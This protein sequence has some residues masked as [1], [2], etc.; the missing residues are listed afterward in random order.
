MAR[1]KQRI[2]GIKKGQASSN[3]DR[4]VKNASMRTR[5]TINRLNMYKSGG[6]AI[7]DRA[8]KIIKPAEFQ[9]QLKSGSVARVEPNRKWFGN[10]RV[11]GQEAL[12]KFQKELGNAVKDPFK[13]V[14]RTSK[15]P[16][17]LLDAK[18]MSGKE[19]VHILDTEPYSEVFSKNRRRKRPNLSFESLAQVAEKVEEKEENYKMEDDIDL[20]RENDGTM[21]HQRNPLLNAGQSKRIWGELY[22]VLDSS[23]VIIQVLDARDPQG[24]RSH[25]IEKYLEKEKPHK[26]LVFL[27][28]K[29]D[30]QPI[31]VTRK[32]VQL[33][34]KERP[35]LA[36]H[37]SITNPFGKGA[38]ISLL[39]QFALLHK[40]KKSIS[41]GFIGYP[42]VG[43]SSVINTM[44]KKKVCNVA[45]I[46]GETKVWQFVALTKRVFLIDCPGVVYSGQQHDETELILRGVCRVENID[47][48]ASHV[49]EV[50]RRAEHVHLAKLYQITGWEKDDSGIEFLEMI[51]RKRGKLLK[52]GEPDV[53]SVAKSVLRDWQY[54][55]IPYLTQPDPNYVTKEKIKEKER[56]ETESDRKQREEVSAK[57]QELEK[58][59]KTEQDL[60]EI[61][62]KN[63]DDP[64][65]YGQDEG[66]SDDEEAEEDDHENK[67]EIPQTLAAGPVSE[68]DLIMAKLAKLRKAN[69]M[70]ILQRQEAVDRN[71]A[72][73]RKMEESVDLGK[74]A[75]EADKDERKAAAQK[76][77]LDEKFKDD[78]EEEVAPGVGL[79]KPKIQKEGT[80]KERRAKERA[81][82]DTKGTNYYSKANVKNKNKDKKVQAELKAK[83]KK[84]NKTGQMRK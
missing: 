15:L 31:A 69:K 18:P 57:R 29:V 56:P 60:D 37:S 17:S 10:T 44:K 2:E 50:L 21:D 9:S 3:P 11:I 7:R 61:K 72:R 78:D 71:A 79:P 65:E 32:W 64:D 55:K 40:D 54:G 6:K 14:L 53:H 24:T 39:R 4:K 42:N 5:G 48:P 83:F 25:H 63:M 66:E 75:R 41:V 81:E 62:E 34:S 84:G 47:D 38:L 49:P 22:R 73:K 36:F 19:K 77:K 67:E 1:I 26:H 82:K 16:L 68:K 58:K 59:L 46:P 20:V 43:K 12:Q 70:G 30:L 76:K 8:G 33:L 51:A 45:P 52:G 28:N 27:L 80:A 74:I 35:T 23:D 13:V